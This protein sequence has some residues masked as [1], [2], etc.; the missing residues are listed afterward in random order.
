VTMRYRTLGTTGT[1]VSVF[2]LG[3]MVLGA[4]GNTDLDECERIVHQAL[5]AGV[6]LIDTADVYAAGETEE[7]VGRALGAR[8]DEVVVATKF[9]NPMGDRPNERGASRR[10]IVQACEASL[11]RLRTDRIDL[12]QMHRPDPDVGFDDLVDALDVLV[13]AGKV[14]HVGTST[15]PAELIVEAQWAAARRKTARFATEQPPY[16]IL[17]REAARDVL[18]TCVRHGVGVL[19]WAPLNGGWLTGKYRRGEPAPAGSRGDY[20]A[21]HMAGTSDVKYDAV[22]RLGAIAADAGLPLAHV[23]L[24]W[25]LEH[26]AVASVLLGPKTPEQLAELLPAAGVRLDRDVLDAIDRVVAPGTTLTAADAGWEPWWLEA[27]HRRRPVD[28]SD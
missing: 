7:I 3:T 8:R 13:R 12:Y 16:S 17:V 22:T 27:R 28:R 6:N 24:A 9:W 21:E 18:P 10:W 5:D 11:R 23:A 15:W 20:A 1:A 4:W 25:A 14:L 2:G 26:P 19:V